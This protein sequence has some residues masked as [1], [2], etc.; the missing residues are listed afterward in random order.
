MSKTSYFPYC[1][2]LYSTKTCLKHQGHL[3]V[4]VKYLWLFLMFLWSMCCDWYAFDWKAFLFA[5]YIYLRKLYL[6][7]CSCSGSS[8]EYS[9]SQPYLWPGPKCMFMT[10]FI[11]IQGS[12]TNT[13]IHSPICGQALNA[14]IFA[15]IYMSPPPPTPRWFFDS[16]KLDAN[17]AKHVSFPAHPSYT[18]HIFSCYIFSFLNF[19]V[20]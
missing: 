12:A 11:A 16:W 5:G 4:K 19:N 18:V 8:C 7:S 3:K 9:D 10:I 13:A 20:A 2:C 1:A 15:A 17:V 6:H 14:N